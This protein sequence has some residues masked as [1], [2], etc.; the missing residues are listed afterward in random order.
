MFCELRLYGVLRSSQ[1]QDSGEL[2]VL[3]EIAGEVEALPNVFIYSPKHIWSTL[4]A[5]ACNRSADS[6]SQETDKPVGI[7]LPL[8]RPC[9]LSTS[10]MA[11]SGVSGCLLPLK[12]LASLLSV[13]VFFCSRI[14]A[15]VRTAKI[16]LAMFHQLV[17][18]FPNTECVI[19]HCGRGSTR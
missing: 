18:D 16:A 2:T 14:R 19:T 11:T 1:R 12:L 10:A 3:S 6:H 9:L 17:S 13:L 5:V 7:R 4:G 8:R 15:H